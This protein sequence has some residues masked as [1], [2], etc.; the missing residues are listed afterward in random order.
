MKRHSTFLLRTLT[1]V[2]GTVLL[3]AVLIMAI[4]NAISP[5]SVLSM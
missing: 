2:Y 4:Y 3:F 1:L 5:R